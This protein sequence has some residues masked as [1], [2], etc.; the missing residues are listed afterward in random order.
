M[1]VSIFIYIL[2][3]FIFLF[4]VYC[5]SL[6]DYVLI[7]RNISQEQLFNMAFGILIIGFLTARIFYVIFSFRT[8]PMALVNFFRFSN[9]EL[10]LGG[11]IIGV[12]SFFLFITRK[13]KMPKDH[14][15]DIFSLSFIVTL[16]W[17]IFFFQVLNLFFKI[18]F[19]LLEI[20]SIFIY[21]AGSVLLS[22]LFSKGKFKNGILY[23]VIAQFVSLIT[24]AK[25]AFVK[26]PKLLL[27]FGKEDIL[28]LSIFLIA[29]VVFIK[30]IGFSLKAK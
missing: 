10:S 8:V 13:K 29:L 9:Q 18:P 6:D 24:I 21:L 11:G 22:Y 5:F 25:D 3:L 15:L 28:L 2:C 7:R 20:F 12:A 16:P 23:L 17:A 19:D 26:S 30:R 14:I 4:C 27:F 1:Q